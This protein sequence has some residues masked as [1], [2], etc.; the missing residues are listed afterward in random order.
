MLNIQDLIEKSESLVELNKELLAI[1]LNQ[2]KH[3]TLV[4]SIMTQLKDNDKSDNTN[5][6][7][8]PEIKD[9]ISTPQKQKKDNQDEDD[10]KT[11]YMDKD[12]FA[13]L[14]P[15]TSFYNDN[16]QG[17]KIFNYIYR[18]PISPIKYTSVFPDL[19]SKD[20][21]HTKFMRRYQKL[22]TMLLKSENGNHPLIRSLCKKKPSLFIVESQFKT[23][24]W[25]ENFQ[26]QLNVIHNC[27]NTIDDNIKLKQMVNVLKQQNSKYQEAMIKGKQQFSNLEQDFYDNRDERDQLYLAMSESKDIIAGKDDKILELTEKLEEMGKSNMEAAGV[28]QNLESDIAE[29]KQKYEQQYL[30]LKKD[31]Y[32]LNQEMKMALNVR[33]QQGLVTSSQ[34]PNRN[35]LRQPL[36]TSLNQESDD[37]TEDEQDDD[38]SDMPKLENELEINRNINNRPVRRINDD[39]NVA[40]IQNIQDV[41][42]IKNDNID[43]F[44]KFMEQYSIK[45]KEDRS[46]DKGRQRFDYKTFKSNIKNIHQSKMNKQN[47]NVKDEYGIHQKQKHQILGHLSKSQPPTSQQNKPTT[48]KY[49]DDTIKISKTIST[50]SSM[51]PTIPSSSTAFTLQGQNL[52]T[53]MK[54]GYKQQQQTLQATKNEQFSSSST[55]SINKYSKNLFKDNSNTNDPNQNWNE[56]I[57]YGGSTP[58]K[59]T[60]QQP[61]LALNDELKAPDRVPGIPLPVNPNPF[62]QLENLKQRRDRAQFRRYDI[63][64]HP[65][66]AIW[67]YNNVHWLLEQNMNV[68][69]TSRMFREDLLSNKLL[70]KLIDNAV[71]YNIFQDYYYIMTK[72]VDWSEVTTIYDKFFKFKYNTR[73]T[74]QQN[75]NHYSMFVMQFTKIKHLEAEY[76]N[77][78]SRVGLVS[79]KDMI[80]QFSSTVPNKSF[81]DKVLDGMVRPQVQLD[82]YV[83]IMEFMNKLIKD[84]TFKASMNSTKTDSIFIKSRKTTKFNKNTKKGGNNGKKNNQNNKVSKPN[85]NNKKK[86]RKKKIPRWKIKCY[87][88]GGK[89]HYASECKFPRKQKDKQENSN[90]KNKSK[91]KNKNKSGEYI[92]ALVDKSVILNDND[93]YIKKRNNTF[94]TSCYRN[95]HE[96]DNCNDY[97]MVMEEDINKTKYNKQLFI[98]GCILIAL[99]VFILLLIILLKYIFN[100][101]GVLFHIKYIIL[102]IL[103]AF[104]LSL[105]SKY[106]YNIIKLTFLTSIISLINSGESTSTYVINY[107]DDN[108]ISKSYDYILPVQSTLWSIKFNQVDT[109]DVLPTLEYGDITVRHDSCA[110][111]SA[112]SKN[113]ARR[114]EDQLVEELP[115]KQVDGPSGPIILYKYLP[116]TVELEKGKYLQIKS[117]TIDKLPF[118][119]IIGN[120]DS[121]NLGFELKQKKDYIHYASDKSIVTDDEE[122]WDKLNYLPGTNGENKNILDNLPPINDPQVRERVINILIDHPNV[123]ANH[124]YDIGKSKVEFKLRLKPNATWKKEKVYALNHKQRQ[125]IKRQLKLLDTSDLIE[126]S[127]FE[128]PAP[129]FLVAKKDP[130]NPTKEPSEYR[131][132]NS[133]IQLN[134]NCLD[135]PHPIPSVNDIIENLGGYRYF[136]VI[137]IRSAYHHI[138]IPEEIRKYLSFST[139][140]GNFRWKVMCFGPKNAPATWARFLNELFIHEDQIYNYF[141]DIIIAGKTKL[142][143]IQ[144]FEKAIRI[145]DDNNTKIRLSKC[146]FVEP[147]ITYLGHVINKNGIKPTSSAVNNVIKFSRPKNKKELKKF[148]GLVGWIS[149]YI[150]N[151]QNYT[152]ELHELTRIK[153]EFNWLPKHEDKFNE[154]KDICSNISI[155]RHINPNKQFILRV[156]A[157]Q[158]GLGAT[159]NQLDD[160]GNEYPVKYGHHKNSLAERKW[161][162]SE[163]ETFA[164][165]YFMNKWKKYLLPRKDT[166]VYCDA[167]TTVN[168]FT[169]PHRKNRINRWISRLQEYQFTC[170]HISG[171]NNIVPDYISRQPKPL[172]NTPINTNGIINDKDYINIFEYINALH[173]VNYKLS[174]CQDCLNGMTLTKLKSI[175]Y[176]LNGLN[177][178]YICKDILNK[179][180]QIWYCRHHKD[181]KICHRSCGNKYLKDY[182]KSLVHPPLN[183]PV[184]AAC[185][186]C[187]NYRQM[188]YNKVIDVNKN[189]IICDKCNNDIQEEY[190]YSCPTYKVSAHPEGY[191]LCKN[192]IFNVYYGI[193]NIE[194]VKLSNNKNTIDV[195]NIKIPTFL[196]NQPSVL[197][198]TTIS[199]KS[200]TF[201]K[202]TIPTSNS[203]KS[204]PNKLNKTDDK[205]DIKEEKE[206]KEEIP[207]LS[208]KGIDLTEEDEEKA[209]IEQPRSKSIPS[210]DK[211]AKEINLKPESKDSTNTV[212]ISNEDTYP[213]APNPTDYT[214]L[215]P[216]FINNQHKN[217]NVKTFKELQEE[218]SILANI[219]GYL[220]TGEIAEPFSKVVKLQLRKHEYKLSRQGILIY[221]STNKNN[222][223]QHYR[224]ELPKSLRNYIV[225][226]YHNDYIHQGIKS[227]I[228]KIRQKFHFIGMYKFIENY[229]GSCTICQKVKPRTKSTRHKIKMETRLPNEFNEQINIDHVGPLPPDSHGNRYVL[230]MMDMFTNYVKLAA[231]PTTSTVHAAESLVNEWI[232][233]YGPPQVSTSDNGPAFTSELAKLTSDLYGY[234]IST[235]TAY[236]PQANGRLEVFNKYWKT[237]IN[238]VLAENEIIDWEDTNWSSLLKNI[239]F[240]WNT[241]PLKRSGISPYQIVFGR[242]EPDLSVLSKNLDD[243]LKDENKLN[244]IRHADELYDTPLEG[245]LIKQKECI[246][247]ITNEHYN[248]S[249]LYYKK[250]NEYLNKNIKNTDKLKFKIGDKVVVESKQ[251]STNRKLRPRFHGPWL[252]IAKSFNNKAFKLRNL[253]SN[254]ERY[255]NFRRLRIF[256]PRHEIRYNV[257]PKR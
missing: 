147:E 112:H 17:K 248:K 148:L 222:N 208:T 88:C 257:I 227:T 124:R 85:N 207:S 70:N 29:L 133:F 245:R 250:R 122:F 226:V 90:A 191:D 198:T 209:V 30:Q 183:H 95:G 192:C 7:Q 96:I 118:D 205:D 50:T 56:E 151:L 94:C 177:K 102:S 25:F 74:I 45:P 130:L 163:L 68:N 190:C 73:Y 232:F 61:E 37:E 154:L 40:E 89:G 116:V 169:K 145:L 240:I 251:A 220:K 166:I 115:P 180:E 132:C 39:E 58:D 23:R 101:N 125:E 224:L 3:K 108:L 161:H 239:E 217:I 230:V 60:K 146:K 48:F 131:F 178:C 141:D 82:N 202:P 2:D 253:R 137:D 142:D 53:F 42:N 47:L 255:F 11:P 206:F 201:T 236:N 223:I 71:P 43:P 150:P 75:W 107:N 114:Y 219:I 185:P 194:P 184:V 117:Y 234:N 13:K 252:I 196:N 254:A 55:S 1:V 182:N 52:T 120:K 31:Y 15:N 140:Y 144:Q 103:L 27:I 249:V 18:Y 228:H 49:M 24:T 38:T 35:Q 212:K 244:I 242:K 186:K 33:D 156:D 67:L 199:S 86:S 91:N 20:Y 62:I 231:V 189:G 28:I 104:I 225:E 171:I 215:R 10:N 69:E 164:V 218:D 153:K 111:F 139:P 195:S 149:Q 127:D 128:Y 8:D 159:L 216:V 203:I 179:N 246:D 72:E 138:P 63:K 76:S 162:S 152:S 110:S 9:F 134:N 188:V 135:D 51:K 66:L 22:I 80:I 256:K 81:Q 92:N 233:T 200:N 6:I 136:C 213:G 105:I 123:I 106:K 100:D 4:N 243:I 59:S 160:N 193:D 155:L 34:D 211:Q 64:K 78:P 176:L 21:D 129:S 175:N 214:R 204:I 65:S 210:N 121:G 109:I 57:V 158:I 19:T 173:N 172:I 113:I 168:L 16:I 235:T 143:T 165:V 36:R 157:S 87:N 83:Q 5:R 99:I 97:C 247:T 77:Y 237:L 41:R 12:K 26:D 54:H 181:I 14:Y 126:P 241:K 197:K 32:Q 174:Q 79:F 221:K 98:N 167:N 170:K 93:E 229:I 238:I 84:E 119:W 44:N 46:V 187:T